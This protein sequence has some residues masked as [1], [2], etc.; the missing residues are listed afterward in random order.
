MKAIIY[1]ELPEMDCAFAALLS[2]RPQKPNRTV[3]HWYGRS[4]MRILKSHNFRF[5]EMQ[6]S[7]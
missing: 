6:F 7:P 1:A 5:P 4:V 3:D 2:S